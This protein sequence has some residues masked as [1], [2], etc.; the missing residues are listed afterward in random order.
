MKRKLT[1]PYSLSFKLSAVRRALEPGCDI[2]KLAEELGIRQIT[3]RKWIILYEIDPEIFSGRKRSPTELEREKARLI[4]E[5]ADIKMENEI[6][7][8]VAASSLKK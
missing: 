2:A 7:K 3:L 8:K 1:H 4:K 6:L 5:I